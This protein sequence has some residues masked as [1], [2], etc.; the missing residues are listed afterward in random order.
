MNEVVQWTTLEGISIKDTIRG[1]T[2]MAAY[3][4]P[5]II[6]TALITWYLSRYLGRYVLQGTGTV[7]KRAR[8]AGAG[9]KLPSMV[10]PTAAG[11]PLSASNNHHTSTDHGQRPTAKRTVPV[12]K[13][14]EDL[15]VF[16]S[17]Y[18]VCLLPRFSFWPLVR[19]LFF[20]RHSF[21]TLQ[22]R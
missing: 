16:T 5:E 15:G 10:G 13:N 7:S 21:A 17:C 12:L 1:S 4:I 22:H 19:S 9:L 6:A 18:W 2:W 20:P 8:F 3:V 11:D 14:V